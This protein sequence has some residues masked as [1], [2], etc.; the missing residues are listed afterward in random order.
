MRLVGTTGSEHFLRC[1]IR[2]RRILR[3]SINANLVGRH[4]DRRCDCTSC[5]RWRHCALIT[6]ALSCFPVL[7]SPWHDVHW[8]L[9]LRSNHDVY[10]V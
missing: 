5:G 1:M 9:D 2:W 7:M 10:V 3:I 6:W 8:N 4:I